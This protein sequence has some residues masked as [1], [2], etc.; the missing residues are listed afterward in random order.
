M[1][2]CHL[3][4][5]EKKHPLFFFLIKDKN[6]YQEDV[7]DIFIFYTYMEIPEHKLVGLWEKVK[8]NHVYFPHSYFFIES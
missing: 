6:L 7:A 3:L 2:T 5:P 4:C 1:D 8:V